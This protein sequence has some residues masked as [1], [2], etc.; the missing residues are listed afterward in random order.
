MDLTRG[1]L[2]L[3][4]AIAW[5][6]ARESEKTVQ[7]RGTEFLIMVSAFRIAESSAV[8]IEAFLGRAAFTASLKSCP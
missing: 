4:W 8:N 3:G 2:E 7:L 5:I 6:V 1:Y